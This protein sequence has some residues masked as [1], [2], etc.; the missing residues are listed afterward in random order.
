MGDIGHYSQEVSTNLQQDIHTQLLTHLGSPLAPN[1]PVDP[2]MIV[3]MYD[4]FAA[5]C[6]RE[7][8]QTVVAQVVSRYS[9]FAIVVGNY[10]NPGGSVGGSA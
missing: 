10:R 7:P 9:G 6:N 8:V 1:A 2:Y 4:S 3:C 5:G